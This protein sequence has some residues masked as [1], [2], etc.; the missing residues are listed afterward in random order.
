MLADTCFHCALPLNGRDDL[1]VLIEGVSRPMCCI[2]CQ[3]VAS[4][5]VNGGL[6]KF[7]Q[8]R[9]A[10]SAP[11]SDDDNNDFSAYDLPEVQADLIRV[12]DQG[13]A[14]IDRKS[15]V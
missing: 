1:S 4:A 8:Y 6:E 7:Y 15:V 14:T 11:N 9:S 5:I 13:L 12:D 3:A 10:N 2:G